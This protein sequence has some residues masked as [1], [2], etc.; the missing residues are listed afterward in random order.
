MNSIKPWFC[1]RLFLLFSLAFLSLGQISYAQNIFLKIQEKNIKNQHLID[2]IGYQNKFSNTLALQ[3]EVSSFSNLLNK[4]GYIQHKIKSPL[5]ENDSTF[6]YTISLEN[7]IRWQKISFSSLGDLDKK[8]LNISNNDTLIPFSNSEI[9][10]QNL[11][12]KLESNGYSVSELS[13]TDH[14]ISSD[15]LFANLFVKMDIQ[16]FLNKIF[17]TPYERFPKN[18]K[19]QMENRFLNKPFSKNIINDIEKEVEQY[20]FVKRK[21]NSEILFTDKQTSLFLYLEKNN[22]NR[23]DGI[24]G[25]STDDNGKVSFNGLLDFQFSNLLHS[26]ELFNVYWKNDGNKQS[27]FDFNAKLP[28]LFGSS[29]AIE[30]NINIFRQDSTLQNTKLSATILYYLYYN[31]Q[32]GI[33]YQ[34]NTSVA[35]ENSLFSTENF[36]NNYLTIYYLHKKTQ[37]HPLFPIVRSIHLQTGIGR[38]KSITENVPQQFFQLQFSQL[39]T[40]HTRH[41]LEWNLNAQHLFSKTLLYNELYRFGGIRSIRGVEENSIWS[42]AFYGLFTEYRFVLSRNLY[43]HSIMDIAYF[44]DTNHTNY[45]LIYSYGAGLGLQTNSGIFNIIYANSVQQN[46]NNKNFRPMFHIS[47]KTSF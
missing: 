16:R 26:G 17:V 2:S 4:L 39:V 21:Q 13:F 42:P 7:P 20:S 12:S 15:T 45:E 47:Y 44:S 32:I 28:Y 9:F 41:Y 24:V 6:V 38:R 25:F 34:N 22:N 1:F 8:V 37:Q 19:K 14:S 46:S 40:F 35:N 30:G 43:I 5:K 29:Y 10:F 33:G 27:Q 18:I 3:N 36:K 11:L 23:F 31:H